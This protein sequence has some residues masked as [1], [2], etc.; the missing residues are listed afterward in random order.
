MNTGIKIIGFTTAALGVYKLS[1]LATTANNLHIIISDARIHKIDLT[2]IV[3]R[4]NVTLQKS[5]QNRIIPFH[6]II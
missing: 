4:C 1:Q 3:F 2:G 6:I 5:D